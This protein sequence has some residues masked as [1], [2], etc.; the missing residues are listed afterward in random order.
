MAIKT[1]SNSP[2]NNILFN[3]QK[4]TGKVRYPDNSGN[5]YSFDYN[6]DNVEVKDFYDESGTYIQL[7]AIQVIPR[8]ELS[9]YDEDR[10]NKLYLFAQ[11][12]LNSSEE[13]KLG[14][15]GSITVDKN[16]K[17]T[18]MQNLVDNIGEGSLQSILQDDYNNTFQF[19][20]QDFDGS[21]NDRYVIFGNGLYNQI[22]TK[23]NKKYLCLYDDIAY[24]SNTKEGCPDIWSIL[25][26]PY[27][28]GDQIEVLLFAML[29]NTQT[30]I[31]SVAQPHI[32]LQ[33]I[34]TNDTL[35]LYTMEKQ[36]EYFFAAK[37]GAANY[38]QIVNTTNADNSE[39]VLNQ[40]L[41]LFS[42]EEESA[43]YNP[44][45]WPFDT[46]ELNEFLGLENCYYSFDC[47]DW[48]PVLKKVKIEKTNLK[49]TERTQK[50][51][52]DLNEE[53]EKVDLTNKGDYFSQ[54]IIYD[55]EEGN[56]RYLNGNGNVLLRAQNTISIP[57]IN[58]LLEI[59]KI[60]YS[61]GDISSYTLLNSSIIRF[62]VNRITYYSYLE[63]A[64]EEA[65]ESM[66]E[67]LVVYNAANEK[68]YQD[69]GK[70]EEKLTVTFKNQP[71]LYLRIYKRE[72]K[73]G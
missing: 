57:I 35:E 48:Y 19:Y 64:T 65:I 44:Y 42:M 12:K 20:Y 60:E 16:F 33:Y 56:T 1:N 13:D 71:P 55:K 24:K 7:R 47:N 31:D 46:K 39:I 50:F 8:D 34:N 41:D 68:V 30:P 22:I 52:I 45:V 23:D 61:G 43:N 15:I 63:P 54:F 3:G 18:T 59:E 32:Q 26:I 36:S 53:R 9:V 66:S 27:K 70:T 21:D 67:E 2:I 72:V 51:F 14:Y 6:K 38:P 58:N 62:I 37:A 40:N 25:Y 28:N 69:D 29:K 73:N 10:E 5:L 4:I 17:L 11:N 49:S